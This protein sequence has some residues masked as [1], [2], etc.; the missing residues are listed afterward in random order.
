M[1]IWGAASGLGGATGVFLGGLLAGGLGWSAVFLVTV[2]V[3]TAAVL[4]ARLVLEEGPRGPRRRFDWRGA[5]TIT[6]AVIAL[7][8][9]ALSVPESG[10]TSIPV[11][12]S[13]AAF[14]GL[15][16]AFV[17][18]EGRTADPLVPLELLR[19]RLMRTGLALAVF[20]GAAR[21][22]AFVLVAL[23]LQQALAMAPQRAGWPWSP[24]R[25]PASSSRSPCCRGCCVPSV[26]DAPWS[27]DWWC[28]PPVTCG[29]GTHRPTPATWSR[30][31]PGCCSS[32]SASRS[33]SCPPPW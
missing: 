17:V 23:Y 15:L 14:A 2:P 6:G 18:L 8:H 31:C 32:R 28:W 3:S 30:F 11:L 7:V 19:S 4:L 9:A 5:A 21:A 33:A 22:S 20:G 1:S 25:S 24:P 27:S 26:R 13:L 10:W 29:W 16:A 12:A